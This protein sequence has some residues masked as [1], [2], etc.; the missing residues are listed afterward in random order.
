MKVSRAD[1]NC[2]QQQPDNMDPLP[3]VGGVAGVEVH[4]QGWHHDEEDVGDGVDKLC[5]MWG[6]SVVVLTPVDRAGACC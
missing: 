5:N 3:T 1:S 2:H 4:Q 6:D